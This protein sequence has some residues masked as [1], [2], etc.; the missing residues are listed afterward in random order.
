MPRLLLLMLLALAGP[1]A[2][3]ARP[4]T[5]DDMLS[6]EAI[7]KVRFDPA[8]RY[9][10]FERY[11]A[12]DE[13]S[14]FGR[15]LVI[16]QMRSK[17]YR[18]DLARSG[19]AVR[20][21]PQ[22]ESDTYTLNTLSPDG[23]FVSY[24][25][26]SA[27]GLSA[28]VHDV[29][30]G[31]PRE[32]DFPADR[33]FLVDPLW[34]SNRSLAFPATA[35]GEPP[36]YFA[37]RAER[38]DRLTERW[39]V[40]RTGRESTASPIGSGRYST[41]SSREGSLIV[42]DAESGEVTSLAAGNFPLWFPSPDG[43]L[44][45]ALRDTR[46]VLEADQR[47]EHGA[48]M[49]GVQKALILFDLA[50]GTPTDLCPGC[51]VLQSSVNWSPAG[52]FL[53]FFARDAG[54]PWDQG[55]FRVYD[56]QTGAVRRVPLGDLTIAIARGGFDMD[57]G[58]AWLGESLVVKARPAGRGDADADADP[59]RSDW[60][61]LRP[62]GAPVNLTA[63]LDGP[64]ED[65]VAIRDDR[66]VVLAAGDA[67]AVD[68]AGNP[69]N[70][71]AAIS[72]PVALWQH[73]SPYG[74]VP[75]HDLRPAPTLLLQ[76][77]DADGAPRLLFVDVATGATAAI[78][79][80][81]PRAEFLAASPA[82]RQAAVLDSSGSVGELLLLGADG[83]RRTVTRINRHL[84]DVAGGTPVRIDHQGPDGGDRI[85][86]LLL[87]PG[88]EAGAPLPTIV[89]VYPG[90]GSRE[91]WT[92][93]DLDTAN[94]LNDHVLAGRGYAVFYPSIPVEYQQ[95]PRDP[96]V[97]LEESVDA[98]IDA[99]V[100][101]GYVDPERLAVQ[102]QSYGG[103]AVGALIGMTNRFKAAVAQSGI[104]N[105][106]SLYGQIDPR[107]RL[108]VEREGINLFA[109]G[110]LESSQGGMGGPP[111]R[112][113]DRYLRNSPIMQVED[114]ETPIM[115]IHGDLDYVPIA[116]PEEYFTALTRLNKDA[117][118]VRYFGEDHV[119]NSPANIRDM[120]NRIFAWYE[121]HIG[122]PVQEGGR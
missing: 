90:A 19:D 23:A 120:W 116:Q 68:A 26:G 92:R 4:Y 109:V 52:R 30:R 93:W 89:N 88:Y 60:H 71:T 95:V 55:S 57:V 72:T 22:E 45:A 122:P 44:L 77:R 104:Y 117:V 84:A 5:V 113:A 25:R 16:G 74:R 112:D 27:S 97:G 106:F 61:L 59:A 108:E 56:R 1:V 31:V 111:W 46:L 40:M 17:L 114:V 119:F 47:I 101:R 105:L 12:F 34:I 38:L 82:T 14:D 63:R 32:L 3:A 70:L 100:A 121:Q 9:L 79:A 13:Q 18:F 41:G 110:L 53:A 29:A 98:A 99:A 73:P 51:D 20:L 11:G 37:L 39:R 33:G 49:G 67:W 50:T 69:T 94:A 96:Y 35:P 43:R 66:L 62:E 36:T 85:S 107:F 8:G 65:V 81:S 87:P 48:N 24:L 58:S 2:G 54:Q 83:S 91:T 102:G 64:P 118:F 78:A 6:T 80:P 28:G 15:P 75:E 76:T 21:F 115:L 103:Y 42:A 86:W 10:V 7:G